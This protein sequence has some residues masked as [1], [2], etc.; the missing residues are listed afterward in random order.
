[1]IMSYGMECVISMQ[2]KYR[3]IVCIIDTMSQQ[4]DLDVNNYTHAE[5][6]AL[7][8]LDPS[9]CTMAEAESKA[10]DALQQVAESQDYTQFFAR[11]REIMTRKI[12]ER[13]RPHDATEFARGPFIYRPLQPSQ[14]PDTL[15]I[16]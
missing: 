6:F 8:S 2:Y 4:L 15:S 7:F 1:M 10:A 12:G 16:N 9:S 11:C 3:I 13:T 5:I 14:H